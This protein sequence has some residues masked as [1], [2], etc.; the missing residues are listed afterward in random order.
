MVESPL[1]PAP[2]EGLSTLCTPPLDESGQPIPELTC[3]PIYYDIQTTVPVPLS[4]PAKVCVT[5]RYAGANGRAAFLALW[6]FN[7]GT[8]TWEQLPPPD[9]EDA[10]FDC[11]LNSALCGCASDAACQIGECVDPTQDPATC[12]DTWNL[13]RVCGM[14]TSFSPFTPLI[15]VP[16]PVTF[17][18]VVNGVVYTGANGPGLQTWTAPATARFQITAQG[19]GGGH[20]TLSTT[21]VGGRGAQVSGEFDL[22]KGDV[23]QILVG[24]QGVSASRSAGGGGGTFVMK[25]RVPLIVAGGGGGVRSDATVNGRDGGTTTSGVAGST[26]ASYTGNFV[27]GGINGGGGARASTFGAGGGGWSGNGV[28]DGTLGEGGFAFLSSVTP[29]KGGAGKSCSPFADGGYGGGGAGNGCFGAGGGGG[30]SGGGGGRIGGGGGSFSAGE[31]SQFGVAT[32]NA[33]GSVTIEV[34]P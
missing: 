32:N 8:H 12:T 29:A 23:L 3:D 33:Q 21:L 15:T 26:T 34:V 6:H 27:A 9:N 5:R 30:Y 22:R 4:E 2:P 14:T 7:E 11:S 1:G 28:A 20:G 18:N 25:D 13:F 10:T 17:S 24:Q 31:N 19:A 16:P